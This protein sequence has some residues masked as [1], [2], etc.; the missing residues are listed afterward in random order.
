MPATQRSRNLADVLPQ[1]IS[2]HSAGACMGPQW[3]KGNL[4]YPR[5]EMRQGHRRRLELAPTVGVA[6]VLP[7]E[8]VPSAPAA[9]AERARSDER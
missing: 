7:V 3:S 6:T 5:G 1:A 4:S 2:E 9:S 8:G